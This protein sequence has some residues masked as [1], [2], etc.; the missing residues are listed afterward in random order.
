M[1]CATTASCTWT[2]P[3]GLPVVPLV[4]C[5][6]AV[7]SGSVGGMAKSVGSRPPAACARSSVPGTA[8]GEPPSPMSSTCARSGSCCAERRH[9]A[10]VERLRRHQH[11]GLT[12]R[13]ARADRLGS[14]RGEQRAEDAAVLERPE[15]GDVELRNASGQGE[16]AVTTPHAETAE[17]VRE[18]ARQLARARVGVVADLALACR[19]SGS[20][21]GRPRARCAWRS[22]ASCAMLSPPPPGRPSSSARAA[23]HVNVA[24]TRS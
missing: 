20:R 10:P 9:L 12:D 19:A 24:R 17:H 1:W 8:V 11:P 7:S 21:S 23:S 16:H 6:S 13:Q 18:A 3:F 2:A 14:E 22:T 15:R 5:R 4:K